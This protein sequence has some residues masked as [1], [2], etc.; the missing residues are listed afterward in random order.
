M[1]S[2]GT[3]STKRCQTSPSASVVSSGR[4][5]TSA[6]TA[7]SQTKKGAALNAATGAASNRLPVVGAPQRQERP[8]YQ[9]SG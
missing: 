9:G 2:R 4:R 3:A 6:A 8:A 5:E 7:S 1:A